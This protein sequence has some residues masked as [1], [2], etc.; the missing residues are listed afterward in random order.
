MKIILLLLAL[1][2]AASAQAAPP[3]AKG[4]PAHG[5][6]LLDKN[7]TSCHVSRVGG[8]GSAIYTRPDRKIKSA[9]AL[10]QQ[11][12]TC[13]ANTG[14]GLFPED[15]NDIGAFLNKNYYHFK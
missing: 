8:D 7:C 2:L 1:C 14:A 5:K 3:F 9:S 15:E 11:I 13:N 10:A 6:A 12:D 4:N